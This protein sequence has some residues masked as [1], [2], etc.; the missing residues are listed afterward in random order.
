MGSVWSHCMVAHFSTLLSCDIE[1]FFPKV[2]K[3]DCITQSQSYSPTISHW[4]PLFPP[5]FW[6]RVCTQVSR[7]L[8]KIDIKVVSVC[9]M[10]NGPSCATTVRMGAFPN[11]GFVQGPSTASAL[12]FAAGTVW[13][14]LMPDT[15]RCQTQHL[16][17]L[18]DLEDACSIT[19][20]FSLCLP[21][22]ITSHTD[23]VIYFCV[24]L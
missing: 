5:I 4:I 9:S 17:Q 18:D 22:K 8:V 1:R 6:V 3:K 16:V 12:L 14:E 21:G 23:A 24:T 20:K 15:S 2:E 10:V 19:Q 7:H 13:D 11:T